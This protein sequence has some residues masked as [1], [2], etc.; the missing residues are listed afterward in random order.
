M[1]NKLR[2]ELAAI[3]TRHGF[4]CIFC[5]NTCKLMRTRCTKQRHICKLIALAVLTGALAEHRFIPL[6]IEYVVGYLEKQPV[7]FSELLERSNIRVFCIRG[8][9][10]GNNRCLYKRTRLVT[11]YMLQ[12]FFGKHL[13]RLVFDI[14]GLSAYHASRSYRA[15]YIPHR[16]NIS[17]M[18]YSAFHIAFNHHLK[19][20][21][22]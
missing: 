16:L 19:R 2:E 11:V 8:K 7:L 1:V 21:R 22:K 5:R 6:E 4:L 14:A 13:I 15:R 10:S 20:R 17:V 3:D 9:R 18:A 12:H